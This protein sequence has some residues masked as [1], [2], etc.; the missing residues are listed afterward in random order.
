MY[1]VDFSLTALANTLTF[2]ART[3][4]LR[5]IVLAASGSVEVDTLI[6]REVDFFALNTGS[7]WTIT[8]R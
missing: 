1:D 6:D 2:Q 7:G 8:S 5:A 3:I 4:A